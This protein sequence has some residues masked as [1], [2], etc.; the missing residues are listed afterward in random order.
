MA[1]VGNGGKLH[2][3]AACNVKIAPSSAVAAMILVSNIRGQ[4]NPPS[5]S[6]DRVLPSNGA[7]QAP[8]SPGRL[9]SVYGRDLG[10]DLGCVGQPDLSGQEPPDPRRA[11]PAIPADRPVY[12]KQLCAVQ[13]F[14]GALPAGL[15]YAQEKQINFKVPQNLPSEG[16]VELK[17]VFQ[18]RSSSVVRL[19]VGADRPKLSLE[20][21]A[22]VGG[23]VWIRVELPYG[24]GVVAYPGG[25]PP[26]DFGCNQVEVR[27]NGTPLARTSLVS[28]QGITGPGNGCGNDISYPESSRAHSGRL[29]LHLQYRFD[30]PGIYEIR[31]ARLRSIFGPEI[32]TRSD[33]T[34]IEILASRPPLPRVAPQDP[35]EILS[36]YLPGIL[37]FPNAATLSVLVEYLYHPD[38]RVRRYAAAALDWWPEAEMERRLA[39][40]IQRKGPSDAVMG[41]YSTR[42][43]PQLIDPMLP[44]LQSENPVLLRGALLGLGWLL[45]T[46]TDRKPGGVEMRAESAIL[47]A[48]ERV[49][50]MG[51][52]EMASMFAVTLSAVRDERARD[53]LWSFVDR[54]IAREQSLIVITWRKD[55][56]DLPRLGSL[57]TARSTGDEIDGQ[58]ASLPYALR[59]SYGNAALPFLEAGLQRS[60]FVFVRTSCA[61]ELVLAGRSAGFAFVAQAIE[62]NARYKQEMVQFIRDTFPEIK[63][64]DEV[65]LLAFLKQRAN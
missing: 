14:V 31:Y 60:G 34:T 24:F 46:D 47:A 6:A 13:V 45:R 19:E 57:L 1:V 52:S 30:T 61:R 4:S 3:G 51:D 54:G 20:G 44:Y 48:T 26:L 50:R 40:A 32:R 33:W 9:F 55:V 17:V 62:G 58:L 49:V 21:V 65:A 37:G 27:R 25:D 59:N 18:G 41:R 36:D 22:K 10:P 38:Q 2:P 23:P 56:R 39:E 8:L 64:A 16:T 7:T 5:F 28:R 35:S 29:P 11:P 43:A 63:K 12:P 42:P 53:T 15:L